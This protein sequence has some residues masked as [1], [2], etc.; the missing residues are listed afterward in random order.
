MPYVLR[1]TLTAI[2][3]TS[4]ILVSLGATTQEVP[5]DHTLLPEVPYLGPLSEDVP[6]VED[7]QPVA[8]ES[9]EP[10]HPVSDSGCAHETAIR[11]AW[12]GTGHEDRAVIIAMR[13]SRCQADAFNPSG[14]SGVFQIMMP[15]HSD[16]VGWTCGSPDMVWDAACN[17]RVA[18]DLWQGSGWR[19]WSETNY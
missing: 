13:E 17:I 6:V 8:V 7:P 1:R 15:L 14:A 19:P 3:L 16:M 4:A 5:P 18:R 12:Q 11:E 2:G 9:Y 10:P